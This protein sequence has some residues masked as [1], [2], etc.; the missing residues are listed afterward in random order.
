MPPTWPT[1]YFHVGR[2]I[3]SLEQSGELDNTLI[4]YIVGDNGASAEGGLEGTFSEI[5]SLIGVQLGLESTV[6]RLDEI[7]E[8]TSEPHV[9]VGWAW[10]MDAL[11]NG[12]SKSPAISV[13]HANPMIVH[14][15]KGIRSKGEQRT[16][17]HHVIDVVPTIL[18]ACKIEHPK[19]VNGIE[20]KPFEGV[21]MVYSFDQGNAKG[22]RTT[23]YFEM[24]CN[25]AIYHEGWVACS[26]F[27]VPWDASR[28]GL[29]FLQAPWE[30]YHVDEDFSQAVDLA[31]SRPD[32]LKELQ[33]KFLEEAKKYDVFH[34]TLAKSN[35][36]DPKLRIAANLH[37]MD[38][39][40]KQRLAARTHR[41]ADLPASSYDQCGTRNSREGCRRSDRM[42]RGVLGRLVPLPP[43]R[44]ASLPLHLLRIADVTIPGTIA[45]PSGKVQ[46]QTDF[47]PDGNPQ[48]GGTLKL[49]VNGTPAVKA[50]STIRIPSRLGTL[51]SGTRLD[52]SCRSC[53]QAE[54]KVRVHRNHSQGHVPA[55]VNHRVA[56][57]RSC[58]LRCHE[59]AYFRRAFFMYGS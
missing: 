46:I 2:L 59:P 45:V 26:H 41:T 31:K 16:S 57:A 21:S 6:N 8:P 19:E 53:V 28:R 51:R 3:E 25:R 23:Q 54:R 10:A 11:S 38:L 44:K 18:D 42:C 35:A 14:W 52:H 39:L 58:A 17:F 13:A 20:Q 27:G 30:L 22:M 34:S 15:P 50:D 9:P 48:G 56:G 40:R 5:A 12:R 37:R 47:T 33:G 32:K 55:Q 7:G 43:R 49:F 36:W 1:R 24:F 29:D 4:F